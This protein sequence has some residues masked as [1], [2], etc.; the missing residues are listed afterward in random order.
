MRIRHITDND[1]GEVARLLRALSHDFIT[2]EG[3]AAAADTFARDNDEAA[4]RSFIR[5]G[6]LYHVAEQDGAI[7][8]FIAV[9]ECKHLFHM[10]VDQGQH[11]RGIAKALWAAARQAALDGGND[12]VFTVNS[13]N[14]AVPVYEAL[15]F[16]R[17]QPTQC[18]NG[19][20]YNPMKLDGRQRD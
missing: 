15:G 18:K 11:R 17:T 14:Y 9:R 4:I 19:I 1:I 8:G 6:M 10:F 20:Y 2:N 13:S 16:V 12:G 3:S 5:A 7:V